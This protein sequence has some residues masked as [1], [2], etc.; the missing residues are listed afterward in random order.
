MTGRRSASNATSR[1]CPATR[2]ELRCPT[3]DLWAQPEFHPAIPE[4]HDGARHV[5]IPALV[6]ADAVAVRQ[7]EQVRN[8]L[9]IEEVFGGDAGR[10]MPRLHP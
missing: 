8:G 4:I 7:G 2:R 6:Q 9:G 3:L 1:S 5:F 10:H